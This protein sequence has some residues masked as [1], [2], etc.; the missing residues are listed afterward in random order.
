MK[1][2]RSSLIFDIAELPKSIQNELLEFGKVQKLKDY[3]AIETNPKKKLKLMKELW[4]KLKDGKW[5]NAK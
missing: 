2:K 4:S 3:A 1:K 5:S